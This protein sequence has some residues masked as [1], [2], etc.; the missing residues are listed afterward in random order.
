MRRHRTAEA[1][2]AISLF[3]FL[4]VLLCTMGVLIVLLVLAVRASQVRAAE[5][6]ESSFAE[7]ETRRE[8]LLDELDL[9]EYRASEF[10]AMR[11]ELQE[12]LAANRA[13][14]A[15][16]EDEMR[17][18]HS[19]ARRMLARRRALESAASPETSEPIATEISQLESEL[20][21]G[22]AEL[23]AM[24]GKSVGQSRLYSI[25]PT[26]TPHG[27]AR[28]PIYVEC[29]PDGIWLQPAGICLD[30][31]DFTTPMLAGNPLD[32]ALLATREHWNRYDPAAA[33]GDPYPLL[34]IRPGGASAYAIARRAMTSWDDEFGYEL[35]EAN[36]EIDWGTPD[37]ELLRSVSAAV[38]NARVRQ[39]QLVEA[40]Q[41]EFLGEPGP[42]HG[43]AGRAGTG[44]GGEFAEGGGGEFAATGMDLD[45]IDGEAAAGGSLTG[46][47]TDKN[48][49]SETNAPDTPLA[50][51]TNGAAQP[52]TNGDGRGQAPPSTR[53]LAETR[54]EDW[55]LPTRTPGATAYRRPIRIFCREH[56]YTL[57]HADPARPAIDIP[58]GES[59]DAAIDGLIH[60]IWIQIEDWGMAEA[61]GYWKPVLRIAADGPGAARASELETKLRGSGIETEG[62]SP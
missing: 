31:D 35:I 19:E 13:I 28:R 4:A 40:G 18:L 55:A 54:G 52:R 53:P 32:A 17:E 57:Y 59:T 50:A 27:T 11:P 47:G 15:H 12:R 42:R 44:A 20:E 24:R 60:E 14:R 8:A 1:G 25:I 62:Q 30:A 48:T 7:L 3:P 34:V 9:E 46:N 5:I 61:G 45:Q 51:G 16:L 33:E 39:H 10:Q 2:I 6:R 49:F 22:Q 29:R 21:S 23:A 43:G 56:S 26:K 37:S 58:I 36:R 38:E 41:I